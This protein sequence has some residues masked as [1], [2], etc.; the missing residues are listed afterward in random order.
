MRGESDLRRPFAPMIS[1]SY[2][3]RQTDHVNVDA[4]GYTFDQ[5][6]SNKL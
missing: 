4:P 3:E 5:R 6:F 1:T 2:V